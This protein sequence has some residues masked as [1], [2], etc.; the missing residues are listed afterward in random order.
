MA[1]LDDL[2]KQELSV[3]PSQVDFTP[4]LLQSISS[5]LQLLG[6]QVSVAKLI[7]M[8]AG[9]APSPSACMRI[10]KTI[11]LDCKFVQRENIHKISA[12]SL[13]CILLLRNENYLILKSYSEDE[14]TVILPEHGNDKSTISMAQL[15]QEY[16]GYAFIIYV[17]P[18]KDDKV[19]KITYA[20][21]KHWFYDVLKRYMS[22]YRSVFIASIFINVLAIIGPLFMMNV[23]DRVIPNMALE[24]LWVLGIGIIV[25]YIFEWAIRIIR[26]SFIERIGRNMDVILSAR[27]MDKILGLDI[28]KSTYSSGDLIHAFRK[29]DSVRDFFSASTVLALVDFP[30]LILFLVILF[31]IGGTIVFIPIVAIVLLLTII[32]IVQPKLFK[33]ANVLHQGEQ[34]KSNLLIEMVT[35][36]EVIK[37]CSAESRM[38]RSFEKI[39]SY[40][41]EQY[42]NNKNIHTSTAS[43]A[44]LLTQLVSVAIIIYGV[45]LI[46]E[47]YMTMGGLIAV[48]MLTAR[49]M[50]F[51]V[52]LGSLLPRWQGTKTA[53]NELNKLMA[54]PEE[55]TTALMDFSQLNHSIEL[56]DVNY[57]FD[58]APLSTLRD[59][60]L[61]ITPGE[62]IGILGNMGAGKS[63]LLRVML[64]ILEPNSGLVKFGGVDMR[65][66]DKQ[67]VRMRMG[68]VPQDNML[69]RGTVKENICLG[70]A[71]A[72]DK[73]L[74]RAAWLAGVNDFVQNS[75]DGYN[76]PVLERGSNL[77]GG[78]RQAITLARA[79]IND[80]D[81]LF[82]DEPT[83]NLDQTTESIVIQRLQSCIRNKTLIINMHR[84]SLLSLVQRLI[85]I[86]DGRIVADGPKGAILE[87]LAKK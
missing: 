44:L 28:S 13:P 24:T 83:S 61:K 78:Q 59:I 54:L 27:V 30:F 12:L 17:A 25:G 21:T 56:V 66:L 34:E 81:I 31:F 55:N 73:L 75:P 86:K 3:K 36:A 71:F 6:K 10:V 51:V 40:T 84:M 45:Y 70:S 62:K 20:Y 23:Y 80:P 46:G 26:T 43:V 76:M 18:E 4:P 69:F 15:E 57:K 64:G 49:S 19:E 37:T 1:T 14:A 74:L 16:A 9:S 29:M 2:A 48:N 22:M 53:L 63:T 32:L 42:K 85:V 65:Q 72:N 7:S 41:A 39:I 79:L 35:G 60:N 47:Q 52:Q 87:K 68:Y 77:S 8:L 82:F 50:S 67:E 33:Q 38:L 11:G 58:K 5:L